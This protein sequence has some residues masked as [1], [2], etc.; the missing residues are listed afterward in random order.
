MRV[1]NVEKPFPAYAGTAPY[2][3]VC[4][5][6]EDAALVF[7]ELDR[8]H[9]S[10][11]NLWYDEGIA[12]GH[13][14]TQDLAQAIDRASRVVF[15]VSRGSVASMHCRREI[16][17]ALE[18][19]KFV[20]CVHL[21]PTDLPAGMKLSLGLAQAILKYE[22]DE[23]AYR[24]KLA[25]ALQSSGPLPRNDKRKV[26]VPRLSA[27]AILGVSLIFAVLLGTGGTWW[28]QQRPASS[29]RSASVSVNGS[30]KTAIAILILS[31]T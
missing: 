22:M 5:G 29:D 25:L 6:H 13:E 30:M 23:P 12:P 7:P 26:R 24:R 2:T 8:L 31:P 28:W 21:E 16:H 1:D 14:W 4:Y 11:V 17:Y 10:G 15:F 18:Q 27:R 3:F 19:Q 20:V 9:Q